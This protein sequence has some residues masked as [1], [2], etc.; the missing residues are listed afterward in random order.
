[1]NEDSK[2]VHNII[3]SLIVGEDAE[4]WV[5]DHK[6]SKNG[7]TDSL[8]FVAHFTKTKHM[9]HIFEEVGEPKPESAKIRFLLDG[10]QC[11]DLQPIV[12]AI[13]AG[14]SLDPHAHLRRRRT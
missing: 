9:F 7:R 11:T 3:Q 12:Q 4:K 14:M 8:T 2:Y 1:L 6:R 10:I 13:G 5:K